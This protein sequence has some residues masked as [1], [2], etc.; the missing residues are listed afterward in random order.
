MAE[1]RG[2]QEFE[3]HMTE[4]ARML[5]TGR[6]VRIGFLQ[7]ATYPDGT[8]V[9]LIAAIHNWGAPRAGIPARPFFSSMV[10]DKSPEWPAAIAGLIRDNNYDARR[11]LQLTGEAIAGQLRQSVIDTNE[12]PLAPATIARKG[13]SKALVDTGHLLQSIDYE[14]QTGE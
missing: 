1:I 9:A 4:I 10:R 2:G 13:F 12:P 7:G 11:V 5:G 8:P 6:G 14:V 3:R